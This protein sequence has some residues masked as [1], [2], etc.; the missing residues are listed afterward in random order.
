MT[1]DTLGADA[2]ASNS[3]TTAKIAND[4]VT[5]AKI[6][7]DAVVAADIA[8]SSITTAKLAD[9][10]VTSAKALNLG[11]RNLIINGDMNVAQ[12]AT[13]VADIGASSGYFTCDRWEIETGNSAGRLT[14]AQ[15]SDSPDGF[16]NSISL[17]CTTADTSIASNEYFRLQQVIEAQNLQSLAK[18]TSSAKQFTLSFYVKGNAAA[19]YG[20]EIYDLDNTR[21]ICSTFNVTTSWNRI[22]I[23]F[24]G[25]TTGAIND[26]NGGG[27]QVGIYLH[28]GSDYNSGTLSTSWA[29]ITTANRTS[30]SNT[31]FYDSTSRT[32]FITGVQLEVGSVATDFEHRSFGEEHLLCQRYF[33]LSN[34]GSEAYQPVGNGIGHAENTSTFTTNWVWHTEMR[35]KP[36][37]AVFEEGNTLGSVFVRQD[38]SYFADGVA[39]ST[40]SK[41]GLRINLTTPNNNAGDTTFQDT[42]PGA[43]YASGTNKAWSAE[44]EL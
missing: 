38:S 34:D 21:H 4:A 11:R 42:L 41:V 14:M 24:D 40:G 36:T 43:V 44:A 27:F 25:D 35:A 8:D 22:S 7:T 23:T 29:S 26:D 37:L 13:S 32:F 28:A 16:N 9:N 30:S 15:N 5:G 19:T 6:P 12:R 33:R 3:V 20:V 10:A 39:I 1:I 17:A 2:L 31:S 18:G